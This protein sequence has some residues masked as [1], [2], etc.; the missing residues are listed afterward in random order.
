MRIYTATSWKN[1]SLVLQVAKMLRSWGH[2]VYCFAEHGAGHYVFT[3]PDVVGP[4]DDGITCLDNDDSCRGYGAD[5]AGLDWSNC[6]I[7][8]NPCGRDAH[9]EAGYGKGQ[10]KLLIILGTWPK[11]EFSLMYKLADRLIRFDDIGLR[12]LRSELEL[13]DALQSKSTEAAHG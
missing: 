2:D 1:E 5:K 9:L 10:G 4:Q 7:M 3:W 13:A 8:I 6:V 12:Y 11:G